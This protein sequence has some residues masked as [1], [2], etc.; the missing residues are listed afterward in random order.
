MNFWDTSALVALG[1]DEPNRQKALRILESDDRMAVWWGTPVEYVSAVSRLEREGS[2]SQ[3]EVSGDPQPP[4]CALPSMVRSPAPPADSDTGA[5]AAPRAS[6]ESSGQSST[7][8]CSCRGGG[9]SRERRLRLFRSPIESRRVARG[10]PNSHGDILFDSHSM[11]TRGHGG[12]TTIDQDQ[13]TGL[14]SIDPA[15]VRRCVQAGI[16][17]GNA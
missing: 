13:E 14:V 1:V 7:R 4:P 17:T 8:S 10:F 5:A 11:T 2:L 6:T 15:T 16:H 12:R 9:G 3:T